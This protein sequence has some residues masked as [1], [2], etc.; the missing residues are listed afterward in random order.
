MFHG[1]VDP[2]VFR[3]LNIRL[4]SPPINKSNGLSIGSMICNSIADEHFSTSNNNSNDPVPI[5]ANCPNKIFSETPFN[6]SDS[7]CAAA[8]IITSTVSSNEHLII[9]PTSCR[10]IPCRV[11]AIRCP[12]VVITSQRRAKCR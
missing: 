6:G 5:L 9:G 8:S 11:M 10:L 4:A 7:A 1:V 12:F 2:I 3:S